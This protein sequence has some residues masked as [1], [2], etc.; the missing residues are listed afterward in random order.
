[1][2]RELLREADGSVRFVP[3]AELEALRGEHY[4]ASNV[5]LE[6]AAAFA[7]PGLHGEAL[8]IEAVFD[9]AASPDA[10]F[11]LR[12]R[13]SADGSEYTEISYSSALGVVMMNRDHSGAGAG[14]ISTAPL[15]PLAE[16]TVKLRLFVDASSVELFANDGVRTITNRIYPD[17][18]SR[19]VHFFTEGTNVVLKSLQAWRLK[20]S[21]IR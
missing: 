18:E 2:P 21:G 6:E 19:G 3:V 14:G 15:V 12:V 7:V 10:V 16:G 8:E 4:E 17:K 20:E 11:G 9:A 5:S 13:T 1:M